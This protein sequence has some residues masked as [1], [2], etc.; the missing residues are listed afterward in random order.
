MLG[1]KP[2]VLDDR[3]STYKPGKDTGRYWDSGAARVQWVIC[4][5]EQLEEGVQVAL[6]RVASAGVFIE[7]TSVV[8][9]LDVDYSIMVVDPSLKDIK[10][11]AISA[12]SKVNAIY[13][14]KDIA[15]NDFISDLRE[16]VMRRG[17][18]LKD[19]PIYSERSVDDLARQITSI[20]K[21]ALLA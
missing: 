8:K 19:L 11:S 10:S 21:A 2:L 18:V 6:G 7:G 13:V 3:A 5:T 9:H 1:E 17:G 20:H 16:R 12:L 14:T 4:T 15:G